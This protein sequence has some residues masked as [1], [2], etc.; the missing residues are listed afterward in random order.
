M[1]TIR[2]TLVA[3]LVC[4][5]LAGMCGQ[6]I[7]AP[8]VLD[9]GFELPDQGAN[10]F[11]QANGTGGGNLTG[12]NW[13]FSDR[14]GLSQNF[15]GF[16]NGGVAAAEGVQLALIQRDGTISQTLSG[17]V[18]GEAY[19]LTV[20]ARGR[21]GQDNDLRVLVDGQI[22]G[23]GKVTAGE[24]FLDHT[25]ASFV[26]AT[27][28]PTL[29]FEATDPFSADR[30]TFVDNVRVNSLGVA[31]APTLTNPGFEAGP[32]HVSPGYG[33]IDGWGSNRP[34]TGVNDHTT[35]IN[36]FLN[37]LTAPEGNRVGFIQRN[38]L[39]GPPTT[40]SQTITGLTPGARYQLQYYENE[41]GMGGAVAG[42]EARLDGTPV[43]PDHEVRRRGQFS[44]VRSVPFVAAGTSAV[45]EI[46]NTNVAG[47]NTLLLD[48]VSVIRRDG[49]VIPDGGFENPVQP[50]NDWKQASGVGG[51][52]LT[53]SAWTITG[54][55]GITRNYSAFQNGR[56]PA[57]EGAQHALFQ[58]IGAMTQT[59]GGFDTGRNYELDLLAMARQ[60]QPYG[61]DLE[62]ILDRGLQTER[63]ILDL[64]EVTANTFTP[65]QSVSFRPTKASHTLTLQTTRSDGDRTTF[66]DDLHLLP[67]ATHAGMA[68]NGPTIITDDATS[69]ISAAKTYTHALDFPAGGGAATINGVVFTDAGYSGANW[70]LLGPN[71]STANDNTGVANPSGAHTMLRDFLYTSGGGDSQLNVTGLTAGQAYEARIYF[72]QWS[73]DRTHNITVTDGQWGDALTF[74][75]DAVNE[76]G[77]LS[78]NYTAQSDGAGGARP[79]MVH[80]GDTVGGASWHHYGFTN[81]AA[82]TAPPVREVTSR[83]L[84]SDSFTVTPPGTPDTYD[85]NVNL[86][87]RQGGC[88]ATIPYRKI[89][90]GVSTSMSQ[91]GNTSAADKT[92]LDGGNVLLAAGGG[93]AELLHNFNEGPL[94]LRVDVAPDVR[95]GSG[96]ANWAAICVGFDPMTAGQPTL[97]Q[98]AYPVNQNSPHFGVL[99]RENGLLQAFDGNTNLTPTQPQYGPSGSGD[100]FIHVDL[101]MNDATDGNPFDG[102]GQ[103]E[104]D[105]FVDNRL[106]FQY[107]KGLGGY[108]N[109]Y[110]SFT[111]NGI[112]Y[113]DNIEIE[114]VPEPATLVL[115]A[116]ALTG[117]AGYVRRRRSC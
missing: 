62:V 114:R 67:G 23:G 78:I 3:F 86:A 73:V 15:S 24:P 37:G 4:A 109:N 94:R 71:A 108:A 80:F 97:N 93:G 64:P 31:A 25:T 2:K 69:D 8:V 104:I 77:Y 56:I 40:L 44:I 47:D 38:D 43:V 79:L 9:A 60:A 50:D 57:P 54:S 12:T 106:V 100:E 112:A 107:T 45:L 13:T 83:L 11:K 33:T 84:V 22:F 98:W 95:P 68:F 82:A 87:N 117:L 113:F 102:V 110:I 48:D 91:I 89:H 10:T 5:L 46:T 35:G 116:L 75:P 99:F 51:G 88:L 111:A 92:I 81:E 76:A 41:R 101:V 14:A 18:P 66:V 61:N 16:Q 30:T 70:Q 32:L 74:N 96:G 115:G 49:P 85:V 17:F 63:K 72:R 27:S 105:V 29:T 65:V 1:L 55:A 36:P 28:T 103:T 59:I 34:S 90:S 42:H 20:A 21:N 6:S 52:D 39:A 19:S 7:G 53:G 58:G 26:A